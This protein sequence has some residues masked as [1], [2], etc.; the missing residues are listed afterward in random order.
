MAIS[1]VGSTLEEVIKSWRKLRNEEV[2]NFYYTP[3]AIKCMK[4]AQGTRAEFVQK[5][6]R[7]GE[8]KHHFGKPS[9]LQRTVG[10]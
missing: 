3:A 10:K 6:V 1:I 4:R 2:H 7:K 8:E 5:F 9:A